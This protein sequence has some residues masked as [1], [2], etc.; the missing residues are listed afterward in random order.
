[1]RNQVGME[2]IKVNQFQVFGL[3]KLQLCMSG[4]TQTT[5]KQ[6]HGKTNL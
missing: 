4:L 1:M 3:Q 6:E 2:G 5:K